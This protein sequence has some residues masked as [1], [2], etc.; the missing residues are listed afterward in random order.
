[1]RRN[2][3]PHRLSCMK[4]KRVTLFALLGIAVVAVLAYFGPGWFSGG[5]VVGQN[6]AATAPAKG[7]PSAKAADAGK[8]A[9]TPV[10]VNVLVVGP[11]RVQEDLQAVGS[12]QSNESVVLRPE[13]PG[14]IAQIAFKDGQTV[15]RGQLLVALDSTVN[16][17]EVAKARAEWELAVSN[18]KRADD[19]ATK[20]FISSSAR[21]Q[22]SSNAQVLEAS[23]RLA[24]AKLSKM[25]IVAPFDGVV[26]IRN[27]SVGDYVKDGADLINVEDVRTLKVDFRLPERY[28]AQVKV[29]QPVEVGADAFPGRSFRGV[30]DAI[31]P[32]VD[33]NGRS[34]ELRARIDNSDG[35]LRPGMFARVRVILGERNDALLVPEEAIVPQGADFFVFRV[36]DRDGQTVAQRVRVRAGV[37]RD[38][39]VEIVE[40]LSAG[41]RIVIA[42]M[43]LARDGQLVRVVNNPS[44]DKSAPGGDKAGP[45][46]AAASSIVAK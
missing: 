13:V 44:S 6:T 22:A 30:L 31:D 4:N 23:L 29:G 34:L 20:N 28:L 1:M 26:G 12:L 40:G 15:K 25:R 46:A 32:R 38:A 36:I 10:P 24:E 16:A 5:G 39:R 37:R 35:V 18:Q 45:A 3:A 43:R 11:G 8:G 21:E 33:A 14:R 27:V 42:G 17:A 7:Q 2:G 19:L 9:A 41:D